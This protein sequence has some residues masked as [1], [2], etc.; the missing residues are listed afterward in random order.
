MAQRPAEQAKALADQIKQGEQST[1]KAKDE[2]IHNDEKKRA[3]YQR[4]F[5][6]RSKTLPR[7]DGPRG[8]RPDT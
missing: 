6:G 1:A 3:D 8:K 5:G 2:D 7:T 4:R